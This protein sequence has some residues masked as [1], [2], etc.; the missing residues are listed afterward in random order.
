MKRLLSAIAVAFIVVLLAGCSFGPRKEPLETAI[1][2]ALVA[3][4]LGIIDAE[5][6]TGADGFSKYLSVYATFDRAT[7]SSDDAIEIVRLSIENCDSDNID[8]IHIGGL[9]GT[10]DGNEFIDF[11]AVGVELGFQRSAVLPNEFTIPWEQAIELVGEH[12]ND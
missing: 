7:V 12:A 4:D 3:S 10:A 2:A 11:G 9:D 5:A 6:S 1:P 8:V